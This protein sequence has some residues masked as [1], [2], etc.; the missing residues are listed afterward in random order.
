MKGFWTGLVFWAVA[1]GGA[2]GVEEYYAGCFGADGRL[3]EGAELK[4]ALCRTSREHARPGGARGRID[5][6]LRAVD[7]CPTNAG[8]VQCV[9][10]LRGTT[11]ATREHAWPVSHGA[12]GAMKSDLHNLR[13]ADRWMNEARGRRDFDDCRGRAWAMETNGCWMTWNAWEPPDES[14]GDLARAAMYMAVRYGEGETGLELVDEEWTGGR[15]L[16]RLSTLLEWNEIDPVDEAERRRNELICERQGNR[17]PFVDHPEWGRAVFEGATETET[18][19]TAESPGRERAGGAAE[20]SGVEV[21]GLEARQRYPWSGLVDI[22]YTVE[23]GSAGERAAVAVR[24]VDGESGETVEMRS[25]EGD[26][27]EGPVGAGARRLT[28]NLG[29]DAPGLVSDA[30]S[31]EMRAWL[32]GGEYLAVDMSG[33]REAASWPVERLD[34]VPEGGWPEEFKT[35]KLLLRRIPAGRFAMGSP[36]GE[37]GRRADETRHEAVL[38]EPYYIGVFE[39]T[40]AQ[41][42]LATGENPSEHQGAMRPVEKVSYEMVRGAKAGAEWP[43]GRAVDAG[44]F[45][46][47]LRAKTGLAFDLPT[48]AQWEHACRAGTETALNSGR[49]LSGGNECGALAVLGRYCYNGGLAGES[50]GK[51]G[52]DSAHT[53]VGCYEPNAWGLYDMHGNVREWCA[54]CYDSYP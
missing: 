28:W 43:S 7:A 44:S 4:A 39:V 22:D 23:P 54:D 40:Q 45:L 47:V 27:A 50:D 19:A 11:N 52:N 14:K 18:G 48:E 12:R 9:Y 8:M 33:G 36:E 21:R 49:D 32:A 38:S 16:G 46:G 42:E 15:Q 17:N 5:S 41:W 35:V 37:T 20:T 25:L 30:F 1:A 31:V 24:G 29:A 26:G 3:L 6:F 13:V 34:G 10:S 2:L 53:A 51:G